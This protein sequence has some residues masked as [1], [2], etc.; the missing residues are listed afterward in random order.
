MTLYFRGW[1]IKSNSPG[2]EIGPINVAS[3]NQA[4]SLILTYIEF[5]LGRN[6]I[7]CLQINQLLKANYKDVSG[8]GEVGV[9]L[10]TPIRQTHMEI[11]KPIIKRLVFVRNATEMMATIHIESSNTHANCT[12]FCVLKVTVT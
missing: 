12:P 8:N 11:Q 10:N 4:A 5:L 3:H 1:A 2:Y 9:R 6:N 7:S